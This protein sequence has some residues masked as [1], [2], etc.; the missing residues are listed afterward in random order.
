MINFWCE[1]RSRRWLELHKGFLIGQITRS[2]T[3]Y[4]CAYVGGF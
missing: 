3:R 1:Y 4:H 2:H